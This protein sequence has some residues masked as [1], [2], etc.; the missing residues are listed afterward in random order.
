MGA[1]SHYRRSLGENYLTI[2]KAASYELRFTNSGNPQLD[3]TNFLDAI[4]M[5]RNGL[6][7]VNTYVR[8]GNFEA[9]QVS[10][11]VYNP[12][13]FAEWQF[14]PASGLSAG[15]GFGQPNHEGNQVAF[16]QGPS[17]TLT[18]VLALPPGLYT[19]QWLDAA[20]RVL[21]RHRVAQR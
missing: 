15:F 3:Q 12:G 4:F 2:P 14:S 21:V 11:N 10:G 18:Q 17:A 1:A 6:P 13:P 19:V 7:D 16:L 5:V 8:D 9:H 20:G